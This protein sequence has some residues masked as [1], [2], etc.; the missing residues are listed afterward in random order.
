MLLS[1]IKHSV[2]AVQ[3]LCVRHAVVT[4]C[5][6]LFAHAPHSPSSL[7]RCC[8]LRRESRSKEKSVQSSLG[9]KEMVWRRVKRTASMTRSPRASVEPT[10]TEDAPLDERRMC[11]GGENSMLCLCSIIPFQITCWNSVGIFNLDRSC[12]CSDSW[13]HRIQ[14]HH[15]CSY[16]QHSH[17]I[18]PDKLVWV[19]QK[20]ADLLWISHRGV[21]RVCTEWCEEQKTSREWR[22]F[23]LNHIDKWYRMW[24]TRLVWG[25]RRSVVTLQLW[26]EKR[27]RFLQK[28]LR[29]H[30]PT[31]LEVDELQ[32]Q[33]NTSGSSTV[34]HLRLSWAEM[35]WTV[36]E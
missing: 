6:Y 11:A 22:F 12:E 24:M 17:L 13:A 3:V 4:V 25:D 34:S 36:E 1:E 18:G 27:K 29:T 28:H 16:T 26:W 35:H 15:I 5:M 33:K 14:R 23:G 19:V 2:K 20:P 31:N 21:S 32:H 30:N 9:G 10:L 8:L 7:M